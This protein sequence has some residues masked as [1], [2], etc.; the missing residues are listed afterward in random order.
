[1]AISKYTPDAAGAPPPPL[2]KGRYCMAFY[3]GRGEWADRVARTLGRLQF[4]VIRGSTRSPYTHCELVAAATP[5]GPGTVAWAISAS[6]RDKGVRA[7]PI[8]FDPGKWDFV[9]L[10]TAP[11][12]AWDRAAAHD[13]K[14]YDYKA[15]WLSHLVAFNR[16]DPDAWFC[17]ELCAHAIGL[18]MPNALSPGALHRALLD[19]ADTRAGAERASGG[20]RRGSRRRGWL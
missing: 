8:S 14:P 3:K 7:K 10:P 2:V 15:M 11:A 6:G 16:E 18:R 17:S 5:P 4:A 19:H 13:G 12:D 20:R 1:M 9:P